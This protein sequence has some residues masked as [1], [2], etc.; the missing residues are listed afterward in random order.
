ME[1]RDADFQLLKVEDRGIEGFDE[2]ENVA[3]EPGEDQGFESADM[4][5]REKESVV[6]NGGVTL[7]PKPE[8][9]RGCPRAFKVDA[10]FLDVPTIQGRP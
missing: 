2:F 8:L 10:R 5:D 7:L 6:G 9:Q 3:R 4:R 1:T